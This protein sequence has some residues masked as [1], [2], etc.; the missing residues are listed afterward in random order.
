MYGDDN[1][2]GD[3][4]DNSIDINCDDNN[5]DGKVDDERVKS[6]HDPTSRKSNGRFN[7]NMHRSHDHQIKLF[8]NN[9]NFV[10]FENPKEFRTPFNGAL[11][12]N[13][14]RQQPSSCNQHETFLRNNDFLK[15]LVVIVVVLARLKTLFIG[16]L[17]W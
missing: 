7:S 17:S 9:K 1:D 10:T 2:S 16:I 12:N 13:N 11:K 4:A 6:R 15:T 3:Y 14:I 8:F 5:D